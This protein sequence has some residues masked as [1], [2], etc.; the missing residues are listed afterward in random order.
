MGGGISWLSLN[1][2]K[3]K[4]AELVSSV[5]S[6]W[7]FSLPNFH[8]LI[9]TTS[10]AIQKACTTRCYFFTLGNVWCCCLRPLFILQTAWKQ[11]SWVASKTVRRTQQCLAENNLVLE[12]PPRLQTLLL[13]WC[14]SVLVNYNLYCSLSLRF[15]SPN[16]TQP[17]QTWCQPHCLLL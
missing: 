5:G 12:G 9:Q 10:S 2:L 3:S 14:I 15:F 16:L 8:D 17:T 7:H 4:I 11:R 1:S 13:I 6:N